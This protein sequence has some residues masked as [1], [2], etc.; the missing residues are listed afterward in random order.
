MNLDAT[1]LKEA[2]QTN[3]ASLTWKVSK[4]VS[5]QKQT[6]MGWLSGSGRKGRKQT[7]LKGYKLSLMSSKNMMYSVVALVNN[8]ESFAGSFPR[9]RDSYI[10]SRHKTSNCV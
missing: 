6:V 9:D 5:L 2:S 1:R 4:I 10:L 8:M 7:L 3:K